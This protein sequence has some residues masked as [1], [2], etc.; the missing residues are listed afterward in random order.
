M[1]AM[2]S[3]SSR[4]RGGNRGGTG[5]GFE[6]TSETYNADHLRKLRAD[7]YALPSAW[8]QTF[9]NGLSRW[10]RKYVVDRN[11]ETPD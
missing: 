3:N 9:L 8:R 10:E 2:K 4:A 11:M 7:Y 5:G 6:R 1:E